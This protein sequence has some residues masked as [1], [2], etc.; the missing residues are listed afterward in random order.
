MQK[1]LHNLWATDLA[2][3]RF[4]VIETNFQTFKFHCLTK[5]YRYQLSVLETCTVFGDTTDIQY[6]SVHLI[7]IFFSLGFNSL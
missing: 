1:G 4:S 2:P 7:Q 3:T 5:I 6:V